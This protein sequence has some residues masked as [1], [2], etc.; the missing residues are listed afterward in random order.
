M[1]NTNI[2]TISQKIES[3]KE[4]DR[5]VDIVKKNLPDNCGAIVRT[6]ADGISVHKIDTCFLKVSLFDGSN[7]TYK[8]SFNVI[9][10]DTFMYRYLLSLYIVIL[11]G[12]INKNSKIIMIIITK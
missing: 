3:E 1:P 4:K 7:N 5:L 9:R 12:Y 8:F 10:Y 11:K 2:I 6:D